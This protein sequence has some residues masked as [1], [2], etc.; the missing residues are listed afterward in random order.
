M[1]SPKS[2]MLMRYRSL[3]TRTDLETLIVLKPFIEEITNKCFC[4][5]KR[6]EMRSVDF[7]FCLEFLVFVRLFFYELP[8]FLDEAVNNVP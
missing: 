8:F 4:R 7:P 3:V 6:H 1:Y 5:D 2:T